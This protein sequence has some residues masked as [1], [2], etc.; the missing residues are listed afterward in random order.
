MKGKSK[1]TY[2]NVECDILIFTLKRKKSPNNKW[3]WN[4]NKSKY[5]CKG[6]WIHIP[7]NQVAEKRKMSF[8]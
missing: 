6:S 8:T 5:K 2:E 3:K 4:K 1:I 7:G